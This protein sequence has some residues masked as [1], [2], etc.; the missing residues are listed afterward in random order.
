MNHEIKNTMFSNILYPKSRRGKI[1]KQKRNWMVVE[2]RTFKM[3]GAQRF[4]ND[5]TKS[6][7]KLF[8]IFQSIEYM[9]S[10]S[11]TQDDAIINIPKMQVV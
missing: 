2:K 11:I 6:L 10:F 7:N 8:K 9:K 5:F 4:Y 1:P 3:H